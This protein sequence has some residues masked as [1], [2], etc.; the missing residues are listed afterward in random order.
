MRNFGKKTRGI[1]TDWPY[2][3]RDNDKIRISEGSI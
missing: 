2:S 1:T 3:R